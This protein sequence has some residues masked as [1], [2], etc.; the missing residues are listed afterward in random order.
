MNFGS[1]TTLTCVSRLDATG[2][3]QSAARP[4]MRVRRQRRGAALLLCMFF[5][6]VVTLMALNIYTSITLEMSA[7]RN[8]IDY[9]RA[10]FLA[11]AGVHQVAA[12]IEAAPTWTGTI[13]DGSYP[14][15]DTYT[16]SAVSGSNNTVVVTARGVSGGI[17][18]TVTATLEP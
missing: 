2:R 11:N 16:A 7:L 13:T 8:T 6:C 18:R 17:S 15:D 10:L 1:K 4:R 5:I 3:L 9:D 14:A 12:Q